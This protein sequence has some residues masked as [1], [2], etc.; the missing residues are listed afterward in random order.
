[1][2]SAYGNAEANTKYC[3]KEGT[4][5]GSPFQFGEPGQ[6]GKSLALDEAIKAVKSGQRLSELVHTHTRAYVIHHRGLEFIRPH[7][8][9]FKSAPREVITLT[10]CTG[11]GK[12][13][14]CESTYPDAYWITDPSGDSNVFFDG[15][16]G[17][18]TII[19]DEFRGWIK[20]SLLLRICD[21]Y[22]VRVN[23]KGSTVVLRHKR[24]IITSNHS[25]DSWYRNVDMA[26][27]FRRCTQHCTLKKA[28]TPEGPNEISIWNASTQT[29]E[30]LKS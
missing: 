30:V 18:D 11:A 29:T 15:Y 24:V 12:S 9:T 8:N 16:D 2:E 20:F 10:G 19:I 23:T 14:Y 28:W 25:P 6:Q 3:L 26:P 22:K 4:T 17:E 13:F 21:R 1:M 27:F 7:F 5:Y